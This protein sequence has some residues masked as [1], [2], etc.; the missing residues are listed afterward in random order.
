MGIEGVLIPSKSKFPSIRVNPL[1]SIWIKNNR[2]KPE[3][4]ELPGEKYQQPGPM[5]R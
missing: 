1:Q 2:T 3:E 5:T 4:L